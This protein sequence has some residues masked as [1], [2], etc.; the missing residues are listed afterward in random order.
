MLKEKKHI[1]TLHFVTQKN[2]IGKTPWEQAEL[3]CKGGAKW[4]SLRTNNMSYAE[5]L[6]MTLKTQQVCKKFGATFIIVDNILLAKEV[7]ADGI[8]LAS[9]TT[10]I[11]QARSF[12]GENAIIGSPANN[13]TDIKLAVELG[14]D[15]IAL[16]P[17]RFT[18]SQRKNESIIGPASFLM[19][20]RKCIEFNIDIP[21]IATGGVAPDDL[22]IFLDLG[23]SGIAVS[24][25]ITMSENP[26][27]ETED[28]ISRLKQL[29]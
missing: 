2:A 29:A 1:P 17:T 15:Y 10:T 25:A 24:S 5:L 7:K 19:I 12:L 22:D 26:S 4:V 18:R 20:K 13:F 14:A 27:L 16:G 6:P 11:D 21:L 23:M 8:H 28:I 9:N 3:A